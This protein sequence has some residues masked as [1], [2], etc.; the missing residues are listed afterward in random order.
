MGS[1]K[2]TLL[3]DP[4]L[5]WG[6]VAFA[7]LVLEMFFITPLLFLWLA[8]AVVALA[9]LVLGWPRSLGGQVLLLGG[10]S[11]VTYPLVRA[12]VRRGNPPPT[13]GDVLDQLHQASPGTVRASGE[14]ELDEPFM[15]SRVWPVVDG[16]H[17]KPGTR[18]RVVDVV[19]N[20]LRVVPL[21]D[22]RHARRA[23]S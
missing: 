1:G 17:L 19:G 10:S 5:V 20:A 15:G 16:E 11:L 21:K 13:T 22:S 18:V 8:A 4:A 3:Q 12:F 6:L 9:E 7:G 2:E 14:V 23:R